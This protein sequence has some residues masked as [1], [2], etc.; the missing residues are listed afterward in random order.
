MKPHVHDRFQRFQPAFKRADQG[1]LLVEH[2]RAEHEQTSTEDLT[3]GNPGGF[4]R[5]L[6]KHARLHREAGSTGMEQV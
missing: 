5:M 6:I 1:D 3:V 4:E 2:L